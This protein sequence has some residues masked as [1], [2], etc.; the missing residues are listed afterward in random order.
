MNSTTKDTTKSLIRKIGLFGIGT[1]AMTT[2]KVEEYTK[3]LI[4][5]GEMN[6]EE[7]KKFVEEVL[8]QKREQV[9]EI[10]NEIENF[11][12]RKIKET[13]DNSGLATKQDMETI[14]ER[15]ERLENKRKEKI[16]ELK[17]EIEK[18]EN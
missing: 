4:E 13:I 8:S 2:E 12:N 14:K 11:M 17:A 9:K 3:C 1:I 6:K 7:G 15:L 5:T 18:L 10:K 16:A